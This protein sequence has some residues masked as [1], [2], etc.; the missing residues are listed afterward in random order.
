LLLLPF[1]RSVLSGSSVFALC[2]SPWPRERRFLGICALVFV[3]LRSA[4][5]PLL[6]DTTF[7]FYSGVF[8]CHYW[9]LFG[10]GYKVLL[11]CSFIAGKIVNQ[12]L[13]LSLSLLL[14]HKG[15]SLLKRRLL[16]SI[17]R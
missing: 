6:V 2:F 9:L 5:L 12:S 4:R 7:A 11:S 14:P 13:S 17:W 1:L 16:K 15:V 8:L 3:F 10:S